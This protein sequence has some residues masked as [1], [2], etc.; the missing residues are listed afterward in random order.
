MESKDIKIAITGAGEKASAVAHGLFNHGFKNIVMTDLSLPRAERREVCFCEAAFEGKKK[1]CGVTCE[2]SEATLYS[3]HQIWSRGNIPLIIAPCDDFLNTLNP[4]VVVYAPM[5]KKKT[6][7]VIHMAPLVI[8]LGPGF[9]A[10]KD[11]HYVIET[12]PN[13]PDLGKVIEHGFADEQTGIPTRVSGLDLE[14]IIKSP[15]TGML[16]CVKDVGDYVKKGDVI[17]YVEEKE[18]TAPISG[19]IWGLIRTPAEV[20]TDLKLG[21]IHPGNDREVCFEITPQANLIAEAV[22]KAI[23]KGFPL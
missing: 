20:V 19:V 14:R 22:H 16:H 21:D 7:P 2:K 13:T 5:Y 9:F 6:V 12:N 11:A 17:G 8:A 1:V 23:L 4:D 10:G 18:M 15:G 3:V